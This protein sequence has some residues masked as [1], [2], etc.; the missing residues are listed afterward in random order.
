MPLKN[1]H[2]HFPN[3]IAPNDEDSIARA[4][5]I[6]DLRVGRHNLR[7]ESPVPI[8]HICLDTLWILEVVPA[9][10]GFTGLVGV[11]ASHGEEFWGTTS[12]DWIKAILASGE[13]LFVQEIELDPLPDV[14]AQLPLL[15]KLQNR[16]RDGIEYYL[17]IETETVCTGMSF[18]NPYLPELVAVEHSCWEL[19]DTIARKSGDETLASFTKSWQEYLGRHLATA[20]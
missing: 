14:L 17:S 10:F 19:A 1:I 6:R 11:A 13:S 8:G 18:F 5:G 2:R 12:P 16:S 9:F 4:L 7:D 20:R 3:L 15:P